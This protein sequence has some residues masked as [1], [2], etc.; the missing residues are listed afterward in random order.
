MN[1]AEEI[2]KEI[3]S[4]KTKEIAKILEN[5]DGNSIVLARTY[6]TALADRQKLEE[7]KSAVLQ[8]ECKEGIEVEEKEKRIKEKVNPIV[9][10]IIKESKAAG[11]TLSEFHILAQLVSLE[12]E[13]AKKEIE[14]TMLD[15]LF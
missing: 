6:M 1:A 11:L 3:V 9:K 14:K 13:K 8:R 2:R 4:P 15:K 10:N 12:Y 7:I 5:L